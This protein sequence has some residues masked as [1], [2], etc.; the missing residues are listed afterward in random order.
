MRA[1]NNNHNIDPSMMS[2]CLMAK[3]RT[4]VRLAMAIMSCLNCRMSY[5][6]TEQMILR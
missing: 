2:I 6:W 4:L 3:A 5:L 1:Y